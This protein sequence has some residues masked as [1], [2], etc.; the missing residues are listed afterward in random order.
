MLTLRAQRCTFSLSQK[1]SSYVLASETDHARRGT[2]HCRQTN[3]IHQSSRCSPWTLQFLARAGISAWS[4]RGRLFAMFKHSDA[5]ERLFSDKAAAQWHTSVRGSQVAPLLVEQTK[6]YEQYLQPGNAARGSDKWVA[7]P[8]VRKI[9]NELIHQGQIEPRR[10]ASYV[11]PGEADSAL[12]VGMGTVGAFAT[13]SSANTSPRTFHRRNFENLQAA[14]ANA[15]HIDARAPGTS[16]NTPSMSPHVSPHIARPP[17]ATGEAEGGLMP[18]PHRRGAHGAFGTSG[19]GSPGSRFERPF[20]P[21]GLAV[22]SRSAHEPTL[23]SFDD[24]MSAQSEPA[25][26]RLH[27]LSSFSERVHQQGQLEQPTPFTQGVQLSP[28][29]ANAGRPGQNLSPRAVRQHHGDLW[30][31]AE[32]NNHPHSQGHSEMLQTGQSCLPICTTDASATYQHS[33]PSYGHNRRSIIAYHAGRSD[34]TVRDS[35]T[36]ASYRNGAG[37]RLTKEYG[38]ESSPRHGRGRS[39]LE[40]LGPY[41]PTRSER[42]VDAL[43]ERTAASAAE[44]LE[45]RRHA[46]TATVPNL[47]EKTESRAREKEDLLSNHMMSGRGSPGLRGTSDILGAND[48]YFRQISAAQERATVDNSR[49]STS[50]FSRTASDRSR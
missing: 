49:S 5:E 4:G 37:R 15:T 31:V 46:T 19:D 27:N 9:D 10:R 38:G 34:S 42:A 23:K 40:Y 3:G 29:E 8:R 16:I 41:G 18:S 25:V 20:W 30:P 26:A 32:R 21:T 24:W 48:R 13:S 39:D 14:E 33:S 6:Q 22:P 2:I 43:R 47:E 45:Y 50:S 12:A 44:G 17:R 28:R 36:D 35:L 1:I 11:A 7:S